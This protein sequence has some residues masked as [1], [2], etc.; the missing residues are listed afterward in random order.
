MKPLPGEA[1]G[2]RVEDLLAAAFEVF[3]AD[4]GHGS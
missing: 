3:L 2:G 4:L 1:A